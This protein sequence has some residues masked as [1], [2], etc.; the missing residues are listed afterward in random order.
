[1]LGRQKQVLQAFQRVQD[2][3]KQNVLADAPPAIARMYRE[4][5]AVV[6][7]AERA[8]VHQG[9]GHRLTRAATQELRA[10]VW[11][12]RDRHLKPIAA[13][14]RATNGGMAGLEHACRLPRRRLPVT[15]LAAEAN[16]VRKCVESHVQ[17]FVD[18]GRKPEFLEQLS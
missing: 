6:S 17:W 4:L 10:A 1:M 7:R 9:T 16:A 3:L 18:H 13:I 11:V 2:W 12:L 8:A 14:A 5:D 15:S